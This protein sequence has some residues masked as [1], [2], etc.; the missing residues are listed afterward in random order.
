MGGQYQTYSETQLLQLMA[1]HDEQ[2]FNEIYGRYAAEMFRNAFH[3]LRHRQLAEDAVQE[4]F[5]SLWKRRTQLDVS[6]LKG[7][8]LNA[9]RY[10]MLQ[11]FK[12]IK[13]DKLLQERLLRITEELRQG[14]PVIYREIQQALAN[15]LSQL[16]EDQ[17]LIYKL[18]REQDMSYTQIAQH[19]NI[20]VKTVEKKMSKS[21]KK[22]RPGMD[23]LFALL[24]LSREI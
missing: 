6:S 10:C 18:N 16:P 14:D 19:L 3:V 1:S 5:I 12:K 2:A 13:K 17:Q 15:I 23:I 8:L 9:T 22:I 4:V 20:S 11:A 21:L 7:Y 24:I